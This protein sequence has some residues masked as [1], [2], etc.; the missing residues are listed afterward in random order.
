MSPPRDSF[1]LRVVPRRPPTAAWE[2][3]VKILLLCSS[4]NGLTQRVWIELRRAGHEVSWTV[5]AGDDDLRATVDAVDPELI[6]CPFLRE[7]VPD[8]VWSTRR[9]VIIHPGPVGD[10]GPSS[11]D[12]AIELGADEWGVTVLQATG[13]VDAGDVWATRTFPIGG[14]SKSGLYRHRSVM[15]PSRRSSRRSARSGRRASGPSASIPVTR[16]RW[17]GRGR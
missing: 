17:A 10:R 1:P 2:H 4:F 8:D 6:L 3:R 5:A 16:A 12:W 14:A 11:L 15:P 13:D 9:T 7:R